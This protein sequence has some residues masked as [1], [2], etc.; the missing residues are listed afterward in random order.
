MSKGA[1][2]QKFKTNGSSVR[3][4]VVMHTHCPKNVLYHT[5]KTGY[6]GKSS[7]TTLRLP[8]GCKCSA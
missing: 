6:G 2:R 3:G 1:L 5:Y 7:L 4:Y 8:H